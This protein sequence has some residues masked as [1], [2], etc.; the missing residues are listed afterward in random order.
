M[1]PIF[2]LFQQK[3]KKL[4][5]KPSETLKWGF[6]SFSFIRCENGAEEISDGAEGLQMYH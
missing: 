2:M 5:V 3:F 1:K 6:C 4:P